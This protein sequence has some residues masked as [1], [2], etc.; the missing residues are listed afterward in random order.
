MSDVVKNI[1]KR[2]IIEYDELLVSRKEILDYILFK[3]KK[4]T[5]SKQKS[6]TGIVIFGPRKRSFF[7]K[8]FLKRF[9]CKDYSVT[10]MEKRPPFVVDII[11]T[12]VPQISYAVKYCRLFSSKCHS[13]FL[14]IEKAFKC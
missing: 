14:A 13:Q 8:G 4:I 11:S 6:P 5:F 10:E 3:A 9:F 7:R 12:S 1:P 2:K